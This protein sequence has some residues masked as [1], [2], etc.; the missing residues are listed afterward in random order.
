MKIFDLSVEVFS[1]SL[2]ESHNFV[3]IFFIQKIFDL[4]KGKTCGLQELLISHKEPLVSRII[5]VVRIWVYVEGFEKPDSIVVPQC[6]DRNIVH[7]GKFANLQV[8]SF[9]NR[10]HNLS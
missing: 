7:F 3:K 1:L 4:R 8:F 6:L 9:I 5:A 10:L 2:V